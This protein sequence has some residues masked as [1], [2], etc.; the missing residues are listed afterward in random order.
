MQTVNVRIIVIVLIFT[1]SAYILGLL[2][3][4]ILQKGTQTSLVETNSSS[5]ELVVPS[6]VVQISGCVPFEGEHWVSPKDI[7]HGPYYILHKGKV[8]GIEYMFSPEDIS[9]EK[10]TK[11]GPEQFV[12]YMQQNNLEFKDVVNDIRSFNFDTMGINVKYFDLHWTPPH[13]GA[14][15][16]HYDMHL[17]VV[18]KSEMDLVC[19]ESTVEEAFAPHLFPEIIKSNIPVPQAP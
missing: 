1:V 5:T 12:T 13:A 2:T 18:D 14:V 10:Y 9:G 6:D 16:P 17:Y 15:H 7:E 11:M 3:F 4:P 8:L 19:P